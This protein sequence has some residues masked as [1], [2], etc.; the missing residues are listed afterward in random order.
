MTE[1]KTYTVHVELEG[2]VDFDGIE[3]TAENA[4]DAII[5]AVDQAYDRVREMSL[6]EW[7]EVGEVEAKE[8]RCTDE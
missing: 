6:G 5:E 8:K 3:I 1:T 2:G 7:V 4:N